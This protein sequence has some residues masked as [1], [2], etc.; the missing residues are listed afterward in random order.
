MG[1][2]QLT[3]DSQYQGSQAFNQ[4][5]STI[6]SVNA[7]TG[8]L[9]ITYPLV[10]L[11]GMHHTIP[12]NI[13][14]VYTS[15]SLGVLGLPVN[16]TLDIS[17]VIPGQSLTTQG[18]SY[19][20]DG[21]W[22]DETGYQSG[23]RYQNNH[24]MKFE[25]IIPPQPLPSGNPGTY[26]YRM[27]YSDGAHDYFDATGKLV[28]H[29]DRFGNYIN[30]FYSDQVSG[31]QNNYL[32]HIVDSH[33][34]VI[35][36]F[37]DLNTLTI[38][39]PNNSQISINYSSRG[40]ENII[41]ALNYAWSFGYET[42]SKISVVNSIT[43]PTNLTTLM[44]YTAID[45]LTPQSSVSSFPAVAT[46]AHVDG[47]NNFLDQTTYT[48][49]YTTA[50]CTFTG[51]AAR[52][53]LSSSVDGLMDSN[54]VGY[55]YDVMVQKL[56]SSGN[57]L[58]ATSIYYNYLH[59]P[60][61]KDEYFVINGKADNY[62]RTINTYEDAG[63]WHSRTTNYDKPISIEQQIWSPIKGNYQ[64]VKQN[65][66]SYDLFGNLLTSQT[67]L[68]DAATKAYISQSKFANTY[69]ATRWG[70]EMPQ[71]TTAMDMVTGYLKQTTY[72]LTTDEKNILSQT[73]LYQ[74]AKDKNLLP[75]KTEAYTYDIIGRITSTTLQWSEG[76]NSY[77]DSLLSITE[78]YHYFYDAD[79]HM[80]QV[81]YTDPLGN[82]S[83]YHFDV[84][85]PGGQLVQ[86]QTALEKVF[87]YTYDVTGQLIQ[88][89][90]SAGYINTITYTLAATSQYN[91]HTV[92]NPLG[93][94]ITSY[95]DAFGRPIKTADNGDP[96]GTSEHRVLRETQYDAIGNVHQT[97]DTLGLVT[98]YQYDSF[99]RQIQITDPLN[100]VTNTLYDDLNLTVTQKLNEQLRQ[101]QEKD[102]LG[103][104]LVVNFYPDS[105]D[106]QIND[107]HQQVMQ[108][109]GF[110]QKTTL[111]GY[112]VDKNTNKVITQ[113]EQNNWIYDAEGNVIVEQ[114]IGYQSSKVQTIENRIYDIHN[115]LLYSNKQITYA[116]S[117][118]YTTYS[119]KS[120][121]D[122][123]GNLLSITNILG[124]VERYTYNADCQL[125]THTRFDGT[126]FT[127]SYDLNG[128]LKNKTWIENKI[129]HSITYSYYNDDSLKSISDG[130]TTL[131]YDY[132]IDGSEK[133]IT[134]PKNNLVQI[135]GY[136][137][138]SRIKTLQDV[139]GALTTY[140]YN[141]VGQLGTT[142]HGPD[143]LTYTYA[144]VNHINGRLANVNLSGKNAWLYQYNYDGWDRMNTVNITDAK[145]NSLLNSNS[146]F[147]LMGRLLTLNLSSQVNDDKNVN[148]SKAFTYD[149]LNQ[150]INANITYSD[151]T[152]YPS[153]SA[154]FTYDGNNNVVKRT[155]NTQTY[156]YEYNAIDQL[157]M[158]GVTY[159]TN[160]RI[161]ADGSGLTYTFNQ[162]DQII[163]VQDTNGK[164]V[165]NYAYYPDG[166]LST[167]IEN[168]EIQQFYY[169]NTIAI[170]VASMQ[171]NVD[172]T[173]W[174]TFLFNAGERVAAY[175]D[176]K[177]ALYY[178]VAQSSTNQTISQETLVGWDYAAYGRNVNA[179]SKTLGASLSFTWK[180]EFNDPTTGLVYLRSRF[181]N[182]NIMRFMSTDTYPLYNKHAFGNGDPINKMDPSGHFS[183]D[184]FLVG[185]ATVVGG[186]LLTLATAGFATPVIIA[187]TLLGSAVMGAGISGTIYGGIDNS[188]KD[189]N[190]GWGA[191]MAA[192][193]IGGLAGGA[194]S[195]AGPAVA[196]AAGVETAAASFAIS[197][198]TGSVIETS[199]SVAGQ[200]MANR[201][202]GVDPNQGL[203]IAAGMGFAG[204]VINGG[205]AWKMSVGKQ[206][207]YH[208]TTKTDGNVLTGI[209]ARTA[210]QNARNII[211]RIDT[212]VGGGEWDVGFYT[213]RNE[214]HVR[215]FIQNYRN[216]TGEMLSVYSRNF[217]VLD[218]SLTT[219]GITHYLPT[220]GIPVYGNLL[221]ER[222]LPTQALEGPMVGGHITQLVFMPHNSLGLRA[223]YY[224]TL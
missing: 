206:I 177:D 168:D 111:A 186:G 135:Y 26:A 4:Y 41:N 9:V 120:I 138:F 13:N 31:V 126:V 130:E 212:T 43:Y 74:Q 190:T 33:N 75:W 185:L 157:Q 30:Y 145:N 70:G 42:I 56:D 39:L 108:Y 52:Y 198:A 202:M 224:A 191:S 196:A 146:T 188:G 29:D 197:V 32:D 97:I 133:S 19:I 137:A 3:D 159:D 180:Q 222:A 169:D 87:F 54:N 112:T 142:Q 16:W 7:N 77:P 94:A 218:R 23:L 24:G 117:A 192:G 164:L 104:I 11:V 208:G 179:S 173:S 67:L 119:D 27:T 161:T 152:K 223:F 160:G 193:A 107:Y 64:S 210:R 98:T 95:Y 141:N 63:D 207:S 116:N 199:G 44:T 36:F 189:F 156:A 118:Q 106:T 96:T 213:A 6:E 219:P 92:T 162:L 200:A 53:T 86:W 93:Y 79:K 88:Q 178:L 78:N 127:F 2:S 28:E 109:N 18:K 148:L 215:H 214:Q 40:V 150:L 183:T 37:Y 99:S 182:P 134:Y 139:S 124:Q 22:S 91:S 174:N 46:L 170:A 90:N 220:M 205:I 154:T 72:T 187:G 80:N 84:S 221:I 201:I 176:D 58:S 110:G 165:L 155:V 166:L 194:A 15:G 128:N 1:K 10:N 115:Q 132:F 102:G 122:A 47:D 69:V 85:L 175:T 82:N 17:Y 65:V 101:V 25:D 103:R 48:F 76:S 144:P 163:A 129:S 195:F 83:I 89:T 21:D 125:L 61:I 100:N 14:L 151:S 149:G 147:D 35:A 216:N 66:S 203:D 140:T 136:D 211:R 81:T 5:L 153:E 121:Y 55:R 184:E 217:R 158:A 123:A 105:S 38:K 8:S 12:L 172:S 45:Y 171:S 143:T 51:Y 34:Q 114:T 71:S 59:L 62:F 209:P 60:L 181:Y 204:G 68:Y 73:V 20:I 167:R 113:L 50:G 131:N 57:L 49:G